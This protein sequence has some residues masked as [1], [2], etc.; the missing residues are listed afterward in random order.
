MYFCSL[1]QDISEWP[2]WLQLLLTCV[3]F[4]DNFYIQS[5]A[6]SSILDLISL[7]RSVAP[8][9]DSE[10]ERRQSDGTVSVVIV[11]ALS[12][13]HLDYLNKHTKFYQVWPGTGYM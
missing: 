8:P 2:E 9:A 7:T 4:V 12:H 5:S 6:I 10:G 1:G 11:P 13:Q 3:C